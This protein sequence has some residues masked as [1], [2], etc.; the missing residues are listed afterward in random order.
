VTGV[1]YGI[2]IHSIGR[3]NIRVIEAEAFDKAY[4]G[5]ILSIARN[6]SL[7]EEKRREEKR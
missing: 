2:E 1:S 6:L 3:T 5:E 4:S 7:R